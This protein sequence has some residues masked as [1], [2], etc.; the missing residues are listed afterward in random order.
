MAF[1]TGIMDRSKDQAE[2]L[3]AKVQSGESVVIRDVSSGML[4]NLIIFHGNELRLSLVA[5]ES[6]QSTE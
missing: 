4:R 6:T 3:F 1:V 2:T 5:P